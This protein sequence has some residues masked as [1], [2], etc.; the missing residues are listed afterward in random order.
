MVPQYRHRQNMKFGFVI[1]YC[2][3]QLAVVVVADDPP[4]H[5]Q[6]I[7]SH[8]PPMPIEER[9]DLPNPIE[10]YDNYVKPGIPVVFKGAAKKFPN[11]N[12]M[13]SDEYLREKHGDFEVLVETAKK[14]D[15]NNPP[16]TMNL[17]NYLSIYEKEDVYVVQT[18]LPPEAF[19]KEAFVPKC[20]LCQGFWDRLNMVIMWLSS[21][22]TKSVLH[23]DSFENLNC[24]LDGTKEFVMIDKKHADLV[25]IDNPDRG[26]SSVDVEKV[27][28]YKYPTLGKLPWYIAN[29]ETGDCFYIPVNWF[30]H[31]SSSQTRNLAIN[32]WW[33]ASKEFKYREE[34]EKSL[35]DI[36]E[37]DTLWN[38]RLNNGIKIEDLTFADAFSEN[39]TT[40]LINLLKITYKT[41]PKEME[42][43][44]KK[45]IL[46]KLQ[47]LFYQ[48]DSNKDKLLSRV[49]ITA[50]TSSIIHDFLTDEAVLDEE[51]D[52]DPYNEVKEEL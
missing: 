2:I 34:C 5:M 37:Y 10:F 40:T 52:D 41:L 38:Y 20:L 16:R 36:P 47:E 31:V 46:E 50:L 25:P 14:E 42:A 18:M 43:K 3:V 45:M 12:D 32:L 22:G 44:E 1:L 17:S 48:G 23:N 27:D 13:K 7:G 33:R 49:E 30:H 24:V 35:A 26:F 15:R 19:T 11:F 29:M 51:G 9:E 28:M 21:G 39:D 8:M 4:G 6:P